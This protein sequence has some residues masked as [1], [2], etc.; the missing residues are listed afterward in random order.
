M[1]WVIRI[2]CG[3]DCEKPL[4]SSVSPHVMICDHVVPELIM[5]AEP[6]LRLT[7]ESVMS[8][9]QDETKP[10]SRDCVYFKGKF[11]CAKSCVSRLKTLLHDHRCAD[12]PVTP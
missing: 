6:D 1:K 5:V 10:C 12:H 9:L 4:F 11:V 8:G 2:K 3:N 7:M